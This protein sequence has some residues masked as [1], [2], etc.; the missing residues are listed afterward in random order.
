[1]KTNLRYVLTSILAII[2]WSCADDEVISP[3]DGVAPFYIT[4]VLEENGVLLPTDAEAG[5]YLKE[6]LISSHRLSPGE[7][8]V[9]FSGAADEMYDLKVVKRGY[10]PYT[11][12]FK[13]QQLKDA[14]AGKPLQVRM[15]PALELVLTSLYD[16]EGYSITL[17]GSGVIT[18]VWPDNSTETHS[19]PADLYREME[20]GSGI[21]RI[22]GD[23]KGISFFRAFGYNTGISEIYGLK[24][25]KAMQT[26]Y[27]GLLFLKDQLDLHQT[28]ELEHIDLFHATLPEW[29]R[30]PQQHQIR[31]V[32]VTLADRNITTDE[33]DLLVNNIYKNTV[34][35][36]IYNGTLHLTDSDTPSATAVDKIQI[37]EDEY[38]WDVNLNL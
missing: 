25:L 33:I 9:G 18:V 22:S 16:D 37:L 11:R 19:L 20:A 3:V 27:P 10:A 15:K 8:R 26:F 31:S 28:R 38:G 2:L 1:M 36:G 17:E 14:L 13:Y 7:N 4:V 24:H 35:R 30:L 23:L 21:I 29:F 5:I 12:S 32:T 34:R 6:T